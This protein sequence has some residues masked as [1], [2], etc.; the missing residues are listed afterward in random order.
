MKTSS[1]SYVAL[2]FFALV[3]SFSMSQAQRGGTIRPADSGRTRLV[4]SNPTMTQGRNIAQGRV[5][6]QSSTGHGGS[7]SRAVDGNTNGRYFSGSTTHTVESANPWWEVDLGGYYE[8]SGVE[9]W[10][11]TD[12]CIERLNNYNIYVKKTTS[13][14]GQAYLTYD[15]RFSA[16]QLNPMVFK[17]T[18]RVGRYVRIQISGRGILSLSEVKIYGTPVAASEAAPPKPAPVATTPKPVGKKTIYLHNKSIYDAYYEVEYKTPG[19]LNTVTTSKRMRQHGNDKMQIP[20]NATIVRMDVKYLQQF[21]WQSKRV[22][23]NRAVGSTSGCYQFKGDLF[24]VSA[25]GC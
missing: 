16:D 19:F 9:I 5:A 4:T 6:R 11:R 15:Q 23:S 10:N 2:I 8:I 3:L 25:G 17:K 1:I 20:N 7:A 24:S 14:V 18:P 13:E 12:C 22:F 21:K